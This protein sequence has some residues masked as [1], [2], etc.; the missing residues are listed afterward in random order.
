MVNNTGIA[1]I[2]R[3]FASG[4]LQLWSRYYITPEEHRLYAGHRRKADDEIFTFY[5]GKKVSINQFFDAMLKLPVR[6]PRARLCLPSVITL[7]AL[8]NL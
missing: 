6:D 5:D 3:M 1:E 8:T 4:Q 7:K 2:E